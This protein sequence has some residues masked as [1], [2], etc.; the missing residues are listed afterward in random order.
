MPRLVLPVLIGYDE[1]ETWVKDIVIE[2]L[3]GDRVVIDGY[4]AVDVA[5]RTW[6]KNRLYVGLALTHA[7]FLGFGDKDH[8]DVLPALGWTKEEN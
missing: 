7:D 8:R 4:V 6:L 5:H 2:P 3:V 1:T